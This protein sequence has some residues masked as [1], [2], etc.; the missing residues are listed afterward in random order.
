[1]LSGRE[2][3]GTDYFVRHPEVDANPLPDHTVLLFQKK[4][5]IAVPINQSGAAIW[6]LCDGAHTLGQMVD[7]LAD[8][9]D[10][11]RSQIENDARGFLGEL[12]RLGLVDRR[13]ST[14]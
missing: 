7:E 12:L 6:K 10:Q 4:T 14:D 3:C 2:L 8:T 13:P 9:Y 5:N 1:M 11:E